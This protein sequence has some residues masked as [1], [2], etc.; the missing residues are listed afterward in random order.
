LPFSGRK[1]Q[2]EGLLYKARQRLT[3]SPWNRRFRL[4]FQQGKPSY[5]GPAFLMS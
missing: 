2:A 3:F 5:A 4:L 1:S